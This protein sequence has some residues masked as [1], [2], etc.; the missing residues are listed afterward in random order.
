MAAGQLSDLGEL[1]ECWKETVVIE[2]DG[3]DHAHAYPGTLMAAG[4]PQNRNHRRGNE[5][6]LA[7]QIFCGLQMCVEESLL[8]VRP[9][10]VGSNREPNSHW[11]KS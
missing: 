3:L 2:E 9:S 6:T 11:I 8:S 1:R 7:E 10:C 4:A 5:V